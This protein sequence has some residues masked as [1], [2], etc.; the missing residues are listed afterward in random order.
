MAALA[1]VGVFAHRPANGDDADTVPDEAILP[2]WLEDHC[3]RLTRPPSSSENNRDRLTNLNLN[4]RRLDYPMM[5]ALTKALAKNVDIQ[6]INL[7]SAISNTPTE[8][9]RLLFGT[10]DDPLIPFAYLLESHASLQVVH[11]SYNKLIDAVCLGRSLVTNQC[12][13]TLHLDYNQLTE[14]TAI[15]LAQGLQSNQTLKTL[16]LRSNQIGDIGGR[17]FA[18][19]LQVNSTLQSLDL[20]KNRLGTGAAHAFRQVLRTRNTSLFDLRLGE[21]PEMGV[22]HDLQVLVQ[23]NRIGRYLLLLRSQC[24]HH[25]PRSPPPPLGLW[26]FVLQRITKAKE[27]QQQQHHCNKIITISVLYYFLQELTPILTGE[28]NGRL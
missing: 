9:H 13:E 21:N 3:R 7:T 19:A 11:L 27:E 16:C 14:T 22:V 8:R 6:A 5:Q 17:A 2:H 25:S 18:T 26:P 12:L 10:Y 4:L 20:S 1:A 28:S 24:R 15:C 23:A